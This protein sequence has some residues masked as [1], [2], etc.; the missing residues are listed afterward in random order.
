MQTYLAG[1]LE[2]RITH[3]DINNFISNV[4]TNYRKNP[5]NAI[6]LEKIKKFFNN[7]N[8]QMI[9]NIDK[10]STMSESDKEYYYKIY[11]FYSQIFGLLRGVNYERKRNNQTLYSLEDLSFIQADGELQELISY[12]VLILGIFRYDSRK[13][14][15]LNDKN[16][17]K[18]AFDIDATKPR[19]IW[20]SLMM[21]DRCSA[22]IKV[23]YNEAGEMTDLLAG[24]TTWSEYTETYRFIK[25]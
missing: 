5:E 4:N 9:T 22:M 10:F 14:Y 7:V 1:Y 15:N 17:F 20:R 11:I 19:D 2:G 8:K 21:K 12:I 24:H 16:Y 6:Y 13:N 25:Q 3:S 18:D 23:V